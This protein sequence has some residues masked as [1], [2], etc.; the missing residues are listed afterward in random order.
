MSCSASSCI[1]L[2]DSA[3]F[4][5]VFLSMSPL[6]AA[7]FMQLLHP[8]LEVF[9]AAL[10]LGFLLFLFLEALA[11]FVLLEFGAVE[12]LEPLVFL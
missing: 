5:S 8:L 9:H 6:R 10:G 11:V 3:I 1:D 7:S 2:R 4:W 12:F